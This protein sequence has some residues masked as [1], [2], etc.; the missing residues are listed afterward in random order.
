MHLGKIGHGHHRH[1]G[2]G[3]VADLELARFAPLVHRDLH[4]AVAGSPQSQLVE[5]V[6]Q[7]LEL[8]FGAREGDLLDPS[9]QAGGALER[10]QILLGLLERVLLLVDR[11][12]LLLVLALGA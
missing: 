12:L 7:L 10:C 5:T 11:Q 8:A 2:V 9:V 4:Q 6:P 1:A 3:G